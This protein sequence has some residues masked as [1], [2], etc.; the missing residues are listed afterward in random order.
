VQE[1]WETRERFYEALDRAVENVRQEMRIKTV[2]MR[3]KDYDLALPIV[4]TYGG[5]VFVAQ[6]GPPTAPVQEQA[7]QLAKLGWQAIECPF[8]G[9]SGAQAFPKPAPVQEPLQ[10][11]WDTLPS[12]KDVEEAMRMKRLNQLATPPAAS[13]QEQVIDHS[14]KDT[15]ELI[16]KWADIY[17]AQTGN[18]Y[19]QA[20][21]DP[22]KVARMA[23]ERTMLACVVA[24]AISQP[25]KPDLLNALKR[26]VDEPN[27]TMS[28]GKALKEII[29]IA[30]AAIAKETGEQA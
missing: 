24:Q 4:D 25:P 2:T 18:L 1:P 3:C 13:V 14:C 11:V 22:S 21:Q 5:H 23:D 7:E 17:A 8:C 29:R 19:A 9:S 16:M 30:R 6:V 12:N 10:S 15:Y 20:A 28:D 26:I 27:N